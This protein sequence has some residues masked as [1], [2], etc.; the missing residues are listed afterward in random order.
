M[1]CKFKLKTGFFETKPCTLSV[2]EKAI[3]VFYDDD[4]DDEEILIMDNDLLSISV[5]IRNHTTTEIRIHTMDAIYTGYSLD[6]NKTDGIIKSF[7][8]EFSHK[9]CIE[10]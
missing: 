4:S 2:R 6:E 9:V 1:V 8:N 10:N 3:S 7:L 5:I